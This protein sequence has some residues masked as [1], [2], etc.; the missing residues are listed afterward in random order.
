MPDTLDIRRSGHGALSAESWISVAYQITG[1][2][3]RRVALVDDVIGNRSD[4]DSAW[5]MG[6]LGTLGFVGADMHAYE[7]KFVPCYT[8]HIEARYMPC[9]SIYRGF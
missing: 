2:S 1:N 8:K 5:D 6:K 7:S 9:R 3:G 4:H